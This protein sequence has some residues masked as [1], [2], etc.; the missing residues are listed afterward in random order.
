MTRKIRLGV[1]VCL[2][3]TVDLLGTL[4]GAP[5]REAAAEVAVNADQ[6][7][8][9]AARR[10]RAQPSAEQTAALLATIPEDHPLRDELR[11]IVRAGPPEGFSAEE[12][13]RLALKFNF[14]SPGS[15]RLRS[16]ASD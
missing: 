1:G 5:I 12:W 11:Q 6:P 4:A 3:A 8:A 14:R 2:L 13:L 9:G 7:A 15:S 16:A 10:T